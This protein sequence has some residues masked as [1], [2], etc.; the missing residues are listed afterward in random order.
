MLTD[1]AFLIAAILSVT[2]LG[3]AKGGF[4]GLGALATPILA[5]AVPPVTAAAIL[6]PI[7][8][9]QDVVSVWAFR[10]T[11]DRHIVLV[12][13]PGALAG[14]AGGWFFAD[15]LSEDAVMAALGA[16]SVAFGLWRLWLER[17]GRTP[18]ASTSP[19]W[20][21]ALFGAAT[22]FTSQIAHA[23]GPPFQ[24]WVGPKRLPHE[25]FVGTSAVLFAAINWAKTPAYLALGQFTQEN[26]ATSA[27]LMPLAIIS[28]F[29]GV[30]LIRRMRTERF[31]TMV[32]LL[33]VALGAKLLFDA[34]G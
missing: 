11:W 34:L 10:R 23:G 3:L 5:L 1:P 20:V 19:G 8:I 17:G 7:L 27:M 24:M 13:L 15:R 32:Y 29:A 31:Y 21:G 18:L 12:M 14:I 6:L 22:G 2:L 30:W 28:T 26:L 9:V 4:A 25:S 33:M 16:I